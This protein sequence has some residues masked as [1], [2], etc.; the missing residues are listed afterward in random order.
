MPTTWSDTYV[1]D[2]G[3]IVSLFA[4]AVAREHE[5]WRQIER[6]VRGMRQLHD[7]WDGEG[8]EAPRRSVVDSVVNLLSQLRAEGMPVPSRAVVSPGGSV[9]LE[10]QHAGGFYLEAEISEPY[11]VEWMQK[12]ANG[13]AEHWAN[14]WQAPRE[15]PEDPCQIE[16]DI[17]ENYLV[18]AY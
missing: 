3:A 15:R 14:R 7:D 1:I 17:W 6:D 8:A 16:S 18:P 2:A 4:D 12:R 5:H 11:R 9:V 13:P 10:W